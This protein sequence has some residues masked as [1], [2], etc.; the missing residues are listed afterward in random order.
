[1]KKFLSSL[2]T[3]KSTAAA[4]SEM[5]VDDVVDQII[6][7]WPAGRAFRVEDALR[8][9]P[10]LK[11]ER[12]ALI[13]FAIEEFADRMDADE[14]LTPVDFAG[15]FPSIRSEL[16]DSLAVD[17][18]LTQLTGLIARQT[19]EADSKI[20][21]PQ[22]GDT[23]ADFKLV[24]QIGKGAFSRVFLAHDL[25][26]KNREVAVKF[27]RNDTHEMEALS[28]L[29][30][31]AIGVVLEVR[32]VPDRDLSAISMQ[33]ISR[34]TLDDVVRHVWKTSAK[35]WR[36]FPRSAQGVFEAVRTANSKGTPEQDWAASDFNDWA[37][38][39]AIQLANGLAASHARDF[40][41]C[42]M[43]PSNVLI[44]LEGKP[45]LIDFNVAFRHDA[46][47]SPANIGGTLP[48]MAPE[49]VRAFA[50]RGFSDVGAQTDLFGLGATLY[51]LLTGRLP[52]GNANSSEDGIRALLES[53][54]QVP[55][56]I[57]SI[58]PE[59]DPRFEAIVMR[60]LSY[61]TSKR[62][63]SAVELARE[64][65][66]VA[67]SRT[68]VATRSASDR[69][70]VAAA[71][72]LTA[73]VL[74]AFSIGQPSKESAPQQPIQNAVVDVTTESTV[75]DDAANG[76]L[77]TAFEAL[78]QAK[79]PEARIA[80]EST[81]AEQPEHEGAKLGLA[82]TLVRLNETKQAEELLN[83]IDWQGR[84]PRELLP[85]R[86][87]CQLWSAIRPNEIADASALLEQ[88]RKFAPDNPA[89]LTNLA[90][91]H[92]KLGRIAAAVPLLERARLNA[93]EQRDIAILL[94]QC[95]TNARAIDA[96]AVTA[97]DA[98]YVEELAK[99]E[100]KSPAHHW[101]FAVGLAVV[102]K[103]L[104]KS[105][106]V[107]AEYLGHQSLQLFERGCLASDERNNWQFLKK[108]LMPEV[109]AAAA[110]R[111]LELPEQGKM[112]FHNS[113][114]YMLDPLIDS[115]FDRTLQADLSSRASQNVVLK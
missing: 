83:S 22:P 99:L 48:F 104:A 79:Y 33:M 102:S 43:K 107:R 38:D 96:L 67:I 14:S 85:F 21:W 84:E 88:A 63:A 71:I 46:N 54:K 94:M 47:Q 37:I 30:H 31:S 45:V 12:R 108:F 82:R 29:Q 87:Y 56:S 36:S 89:I 114:I 103:G 64:L 7:N 9:Y 80:F 74:A 57:R 1:M 59:I 55:P 110:P 35:R 32:D 68:Q 77:T 61:E 69:K 50:G 66:Q 34:T 62:P 93:P 53:R 25:A 41:H 111:L 2:F 112:L 100:I 52:F 115:A 113:R 23:I 101:E 3:R 106:P 73:G 76:I 40:I 17:L 70:R 26:L 58:N 86:G 95:Y 98:A 78:S 75:S 15:R 105:D 109:L 91:S 16:L 27:C 13:E 5:S 18:A 97:F 28:Q 6:G 44:T 39:L 4:T 81:L 60:C 42:D 92:L 20:K 65:Q 90:Y 10:E 19:S 8:L 11:A 72:A 51:Q 49:Q 24:E